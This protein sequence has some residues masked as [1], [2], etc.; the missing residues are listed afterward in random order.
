MRG[1]KKWWR[2]RLSVS[3]VTAQSRCLPTRLHHMTPGEKEA[4]KKFAFSKHT[5]EH[6]Q[7]DS[8]YHHEAYI[9]AG[10]YMILEYS[11]LSPSNQDL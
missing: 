8:L 2:R 6:A 3:I 1:A 4:A 11:I 7:R 5:E 10:D 9:Q